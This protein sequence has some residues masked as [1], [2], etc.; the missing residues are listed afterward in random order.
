VIVDGS[1]SIDHRSRTHGPT[2]ATRCSHSI[3]PA[4]VSTALTRSPANRKPVTVTPV[5]MVA[6]APRT[7]SARPRSEATLLAYPPRFSCRITETPGAC[8]S[9]NISLMYSWQASTPSTS[10]ESYPMACC[11]AW[12]CTTSSCI[13]SGAAWT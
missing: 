4:S 10:T 12:I 3:V 11:S 9:E 13:A 1:P 8:Q 2:A 6:P 7:L 5:R